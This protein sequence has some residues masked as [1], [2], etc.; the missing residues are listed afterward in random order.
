[1]ISCSICC[2]FLDKRCN[3][4][5]R[6]GNVTVYPDLPQMDHRNSFPQFL[7]YVKAK[8]TITMMDVC[9]GQRERAFF[10]TLFKALKIR[11]ISN[12]LGFAEGSEPGLIAYKVFGTIESVDDLFYLSLMIGFHKYSA[13]LMLYE[14]YAS[15]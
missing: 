2:S 4:K 11:L 14:T 8:G 9:V 10:R 15:C 6:T 12:V 5:A 7:T 13:G 1:M 3:E